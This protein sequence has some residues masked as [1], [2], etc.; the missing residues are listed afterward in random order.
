M[1]TAEQLP[2]EQMTL[3]AMDEAL[4]VAG[5]Y[6][7]PF[8]SY[9]PERS[10]VPAVAREALSTTVISH[11]YANGLI[12]SLS[13]EVLPGKTGLVYTCALC[14][15]LATEDEPANIVYGRGRSSV[16]AVAIAAL[17][18]KRIV[19]DEGQSDEEF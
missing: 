8:S 6:G 13:I 2:I 10:E 9:G 1:E 11:L 12:I 18:I 7:R 17:N 19:A 14:R 5:V 4:V 16:V 15:S 3:A